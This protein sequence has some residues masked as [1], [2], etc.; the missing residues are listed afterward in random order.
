MK[1]CIVLIL[2]AITIFNLSIAIAAKEV[3]N[4]LTDVV[5][6]DGT[7]KDKGGVFLN[8]PYSYIEIENVDFTGIKSI[9]VKAVAEVFG[10]A[11]G[12]QLQ[13][14][15]DN[16]AG[17]LLGYVDIGKDTKG[18]EEIFKASL[19]YNVKGM[20]DL[21]ILSSIAT[22]NTVK[23]TEITL[24]EEV[25]KEKAY[26]PVPDSA[27]RDDHHTT[28]ALTDSLGRKVASYSEAGDK[29]EGKFAGMFYWT[30]HTNTIRPT[31][32]S[33]FAKEHP[34]ARFD[35]HHPAW[36]KD[37]TANYWNEPLFG[38]YN[39]EDY[40]VYRKHMEMLSAADIDVIFFDC[41]N[42]DSTFRAQYE[43]LFTAMTDAK[44][45][46]LKVPGFSFMLGLF[47]TP[48]S[49]RTSL[50]NKSKRVYLNIYKDEKWKDLWFYWEGK[51]LL[52][53][54]DNVL[55]PR[56]VGNEVDTEE[57]YLIEDIKDFFTF[58]PIKSTY[59]SE[60]DR[61][62][63]WGWIGVYPQ[64]GFAP[65][66]DGTFEQAVVSVAANYSSVTNS[67]TA[68]NN[69]YAM[70]RSYTS[71][72]GHDL[73]PNA[74]I[75]GHFFSESVRR[76]LEIDPE[77]MFITG[78]N[79]WK[80]GRYESWGGTLNGSPDSY[81]NEASRDLEPTKGEAKDNYY[82]L[83]VDAVRRFK[84]VEPTPVA[85]VEKTIDLNNIDSWQGVTP[86]FINTEGTYN[87]DSKGSQY[88]PY[89]N[90][91]V[92]NNIIK[93]KVSRD[94]ENIY[95]YAECAEEIVGEGKDN[96]MKLYIDKDRNHAT[97]WEGYD[98]V[99]N[100]PGKGDISVLNAE[101]DAT[102]VGKAELVLS[103]KILTLKIKRDVIGLTDPLCFEFKWIDNADGDIL[104][105]YS[106]GDAAP[107]GRFNYV[108]TVIAEKYLDE[109]MR[110]AL[111]GTAV[112]QEWSN[113][114]Y[115][116]G[117]KMFLYDPDTRYGART[118]NGV[119][120]IP[121]YFLENTFNIRPTYEAA[122]N[123]VKLEGEKEVYTYVGT[124]EARCDGA[125]VTLKDPVTVI[126][127]I[128]YLPM[129]FFADVEGFSVYSS[130]NK[131]AFGKNIDQGAVDS[132][133]F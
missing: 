15:L 4:P 90:Y 21:Y 96:W 55:T 56:K 30:W 119:V 3:I 6:S 61:D 37:S 34:D 76:A 50:M 73:R 5:L 49:E 54:Y 2:I 14:R 109:N 103:G 20:H 65:N 51:P 114:V 126:D 45:D 27:I 128:P 113:K 42:G 121:A 78:W 17:L 26:E 24:S 19:Y 106:D 81:D 95:F 87:R 39:S 91:T 107:L 100:Y 118:I 33:L 97:G 11:D 41:T 84:G 108:Y 67:F 122:R 16:S 63:Q 68:M 130:G 44:K 131:W 53:A 38:Y 7:I 93:S 71:V 125:L 69:L 32:M 104:N 8:K 102:V 133:E 85:G 9:E 62:D 86:E 25:Y 28:W 88:M 111:S 75:Y 127:G 43:T 98:Y 35:Y 47:D 31:N 120:Y 46:G 124:L 77:M 59:R 101:D 132:L 72:Q 60:Y 123:I 18:A 99:I 23:I 112:I 1:K 36:P 79:E 13:L 40:W 89:E 82:C 74:Y 116:S 66:P 29:R 22:A 115:V 64:N 57:L 58:R 117:K 48:E 70:G 92:R 110:N 80:A 105:W 129:S 10:G 94:S 83:L 52:L 12:E